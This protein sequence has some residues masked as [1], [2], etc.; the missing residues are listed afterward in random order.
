MGGGKG[1][2]EKIITSIYLVLVGGAREH[3]GMNVAI[4]RQPVGLGSPLLLGMELRCGSKCLYPLRHLTDPSTDVS[5]S[6]VKHTFFD[7]SS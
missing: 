5:G 4:R 1:D 3:Q 2:I 6:F 7:L